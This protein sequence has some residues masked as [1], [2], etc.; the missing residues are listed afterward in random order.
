MDRFKIIHEPKIERYEPIVG[1]VFKRGS[2]YLR[3]VEDISCDECYFSIETPYGFSPISCNTPTTFRPICDERRDGKSII[4][5]KITSL[6]LNFRDME[7]YSKR[8]GYSYNIKDI[9]HMIQSYFDRKTGH[10]IS[11]TTRDVV[12]TFSVLLRS[13]FNHMWE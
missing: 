4:F 6:D 12:R 3:C 10:Y 9:D 8:A 1:E 13:E 11:H 5:K 2:T 7:I